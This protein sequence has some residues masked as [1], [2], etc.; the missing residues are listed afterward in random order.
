MKG[1][2]YIIPIFVPNEG[3]P[4]N[5]V[6]CNQSIITGNEQKVDA[7]FV[8][9]TVEEYLKTIKR[10]NSTVEVSFF[11]GTF[12]AIPLGRQ[13]ELLKIA[14]E[15]KNR[16]DIDY[17]R[18]ST[19]P[20][21]ID[22]NILDN[23]KNY[24]VDII[25]LGIQSLD[26]EVLIKSGRG[27]SFEDAEKASFLIKKYG[28]VL[29]HQIMLGLPRD[30]FQ[31]DIKTVKESIGMGPDIYRLYPALVIR[32]T[33]ME[34]MY[35]KGIYRPYSLSEAVD[36]CK[37]LYCI[38]RAKGVKVIRIGLQPTE[39]INTGADVVAGPFH[40]AFRELVEG[41]IYNSIVEKIIPDF[42]KGD[43][44]VKIN[45]RDLSKLYADR[46]RYFNDMKNKFSHCRVKVLQSESVDRGTLCIDGRNLHEI[47]SIDDY[48]R[49][50]CLS[51]NLV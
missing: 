32:E 7:D 14:K 25:E 19:R 35:K 15:Y 24:S 30:S 4:H 44:T 31:K 16:G 48:M 1:R 20:D 10:E 5:C 46:K 29:G 2:H 18:L 43:I 42:Q 45:Y 12:T 34:I 49:D 33:A 39:E 3:C 11:G 28:F 38:L 47:I 51:R 13:K 17:I 23:L 21:Y 37:I 27:H 22:E 36:I 6:F 40:P 50:E 41:S 26:R 9:R 8:R